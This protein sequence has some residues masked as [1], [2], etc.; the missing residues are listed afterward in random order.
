[1]GETDKIYYAITGIGIN[2]NMERK[3]LTDD[4]VDIATS[5]KMETGKSVV[6][7]EMLLGN[8]FVPTS[9]SQKF[10]SQETGL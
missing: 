6:R 1:M 9:L 10:Y 7:A 4:I 3:D 5:V 8:V 2:A